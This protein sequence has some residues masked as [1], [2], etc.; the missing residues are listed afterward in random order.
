MKGSPGVYQH[1]YTNANID[2]WWVKIWLKIFPALKNPNTD[3]SILI[4]TYLAF[5]GPSGIHA[6]WDIETNGRFEAERPPTS[7]GPHSGGRAAT[8]VPY[9]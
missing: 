6:G 9:V 3:M 4:Y 2:L 8:F 1:G 5:A 7:A